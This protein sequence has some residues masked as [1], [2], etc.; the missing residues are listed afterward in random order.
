MSKYLG[1]NF[2]AKIEHVLHEVSDYL[3]DL[4]QYVQVDP[5][6]M[7]AT[8]TKITEVYDCFEQDIV[9]LH[10]L[11]EEFIASIDEGDE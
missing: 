8:V 7:K 5:G 2:I 9:E 4:D 11:K 6:T 1:V 3:K 10:Q